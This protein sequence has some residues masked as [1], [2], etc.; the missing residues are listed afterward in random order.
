MTEYT[1]VGVPAPRGGPCDVYVVEGTLPSPV[2]DSAIHH[3]KT[4]GKHLDPR[5]ELRNHS[6]SGFAWGYGGSGPAQL[7]LAILAHELDDE[8]ALGDYQ[9]FKFDIVAGLNGDEPFALT[10][11]D[12]RQA[13]DSM[14]SKKA[15]RA[16]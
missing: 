12:V 1:Y 16:D 13:L 3:A 5:G 14:D 4:E 15:L 11:R 9:A 6:P 10:S 7:S 8:T 2:N